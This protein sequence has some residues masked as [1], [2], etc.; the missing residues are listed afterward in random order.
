[1]GTLRHTYSRVGLVLESD[2]RAISMTRGGQL[3]LLT[4]NTRYV[5]IYI[6]MGGGQGSK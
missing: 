4:E 6:I 3:V 1:M 5:I 2:G